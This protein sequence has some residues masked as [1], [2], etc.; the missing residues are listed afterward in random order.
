MR[1]HDPDRV[2]VYFESQPALPENSGVTSVTV[3]KH[4][5]LRPDLPVVVERRDDGSVA[6]DVPY[7]PRPLCGLWGVCE[8]PPRLLDSSYQ[9]VAGTE[10]TLVEPDGRLLASAYVPGADS[11]S[12]SGG[13]VI[14]RHVYARYWASHPRM[15]ETGPF[16]VWM[17]TP[18]SNV[19]TIESHKSPI[20]GLGLVALLV[21]APFAIG[22]VALSMDRDASV[23]AVGGVTLGIPAF[24]L[25]GA[26][27]ALLTWPETTSIEHPSR[28][29]A[30]R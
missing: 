1:V 14:M 4:R 15:V 29:V 21:A 18:A 8:H 20:R 23:R 16:E 22:A 28:D 26:G 7:H 25:G 10:E 19:E 17:K 24:L 6:L 11:L 9:P 3:E 27:V 5:P 30:G 13:Y 12:V 2:G